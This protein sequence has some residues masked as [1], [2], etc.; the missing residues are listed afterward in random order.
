MNIG[1]SSSSIHDNVLQSARTQMQDAHANVNARNDAIKAMKEDIQAGDMDGAA[2]EQQ[3]ALAAEQNVLASR[4]SLKDF[5]TSVGQMRGEMSQLAQDH[6]TF[7]DSM[8]AG[9]IDAAK[10]AFA[11]FHQDQQTIRTDLQNLGINPPSPSVS[12]TA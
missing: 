6:Q 9:N 2:Q 1:S 8:Q 4:S 10:T 5:H 7:I 11:A 3:A 12:V